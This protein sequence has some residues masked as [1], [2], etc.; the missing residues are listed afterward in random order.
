MP[1]PPAL[2]WSEKPI[3]VESTL[4]VSLGDSLGLDTAV[5]AAV[6]A[7][8]AAV[9]AAAAVPVAEEGAVAEALTWETGAVYKY[10]AKRL[11]RNTRTTDTQNF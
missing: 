7:A 8:V 6:P 9:P 4:A 10:V 3:A 5:V 2:K 1:P 11:L